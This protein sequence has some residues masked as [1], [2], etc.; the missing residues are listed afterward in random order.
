MMFPYLEKLCCVILQFFIP[1]LLIGHRTYWWVKLKN[2]SI[3]RLFQTPI[4]CE[5]GPGNP[6]GHVMINMIIGLWIVKLIET[7]FYPQG[8]GASPIKIV[9]KRIS[10]NLFYAWVGIIV[11]SR[12]FI[13]A[14]F[15]HQCILAILMGLFTY[16]AVSNYIRYFHGTFKKIIMAFGILASALLVYAYAEVLTGLDVNWSIAL[17]KKYCSKV[18][19]LIPICISIFLLFVTLKRGQSFE[20]KSFHSHFRKNGYT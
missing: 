19:L 17:A 13:L 4:T 9:I 10:W 6:S 16:K 1:R 12:I 14:H 15:P 8:A 5:T 3:Q 7:L 2:L 18:N 20:V 11:I